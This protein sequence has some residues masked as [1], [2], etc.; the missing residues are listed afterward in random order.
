MFWPVLIRFDDFTGLSLIRNLSPH[1]MMARVYAQLAP[2]QVIS[3]QF[4][5]DTVVDARV[6]WS[7]GQRIGVEF[8]REIDVDAI[9]SRFGR[10]NNGTGEDRAPRL[11]IDCGC[12]I[13][14]ESGTLAVDVR[15]ISQRGVKIATSRLRPGDEVTIH[16]PRMRPKKAVVRWVQ[17][18]TAGLNFL[19]P[20]GFEDL[21]RWVIEQQ[22]LSSAAGPG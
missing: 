18:E 5:Q 11:Q 22:T 7:N 4:N 2:E 6:V 16:L 12:E 1:G 15:D 9:L 13:L 20:L 10:Q 17:Q 8:D 3:V 14:T 19:D 21:A